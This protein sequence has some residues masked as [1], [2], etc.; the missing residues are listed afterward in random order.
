[1]YNNQTTCKIYIQLG[2][3]PFNLEESIQ[4]ARYIFNLEDI[5]S[6]CKIYI[7]FARYTF[8]LKISIQ[9]EDIYLTWKIHI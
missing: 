7:Q 9:L 1:M 8:N 4:L 3:Y 2:R 6:T 5:Y